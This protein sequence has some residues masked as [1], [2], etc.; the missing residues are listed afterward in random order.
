MRLEAKSVFFRLLTIRS[1]FCCGNPFSFK[2]ATNS[3]AMSHGKAVELA[4]NTRGMLSVFSE[5]MKQ[6]KLV[7]LE[8]E[9]YELTTKNMPVFIDVKDQ[10][11]KKDFTQDHWNY[12]RL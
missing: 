8:Q 3:K 5:R 12:W 10:F 2:K 6:R 4:A 1:F 11:S 9:F 7:M